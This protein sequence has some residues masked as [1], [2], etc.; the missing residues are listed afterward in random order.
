MKTAEANGEFLEDLISSACS[1]VHITDNLTGFAELRRP[2]SHIECCT[3]PAPVFGNKKPQRTMPQ[4]YAGSAQAPSISFGSQNRP[5]PSLDRRFKD[6]PTTPAT[7]AAGAQPPTADS[8]EAQDF[9]APRSRR[10]VPTASAPTIASSDNPGVPCSPLRLMSRL[11]GAPASVCTMSG[12]FCRHALHSKTGMPI[13][14]FLHC[15]S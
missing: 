3:Q 10:A 13:A 9:G 11:P 8:Q 14:H 4:L 5:P 12:A 15:L 1:S 2:D 6:R 7:Q